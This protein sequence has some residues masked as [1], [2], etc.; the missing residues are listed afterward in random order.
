M[1]DN[2][3]NSII[4]PIPLSQIEE[5]VAAHLGPGRIRS[6]AAAPCLS[7]QV[8]MYLAKHIAGWSLPK[9]GRF[10]NGRHH[11]TVL[12]GIG[13]IERLRKTD[14]AFDAL[15]DVLAATLASEG[16]RGPAVC[17]AHSEL[18]DAVALRVIQRL[19]E[20]PVDRRTIQA[21]TTVDV[22]PTS[23]SNG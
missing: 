19:K 21:T 9:I 8:S 3:R 2:S 5:I 20:Q 7:R 17:V 10:Y 15:M 18:I 16:N 14:D 4:W 22:S 12:H 11:T 6:N 1:P 23:A 13:K